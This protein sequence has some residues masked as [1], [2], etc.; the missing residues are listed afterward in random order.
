MRLLF[1]GDMVGKTGRTAVWEQ[2][3]GLIADFKLDFVI[4]NG[5]NAA[6]GFGITEEIFRETISAG[7]DVVT[8]GNHVWDQ[9]DALVFAP[10]EE[11]FLRPSNFPKGTPGRGSGVYIARNGARVL[12]ANIMGRV[13]MHPE[14]DDP[15]QAGERELT[16]CPLGE[17]ADAAVID[18]HAEATSE[19]MCF[20]HFVDGRASL[21]VG[22]HT[23]QPTGDH[24]ILNGGTG[25]ISDAGMCGDYD[26][27][28]GMDKEEPLN[29][30]LSK[31]PKGRFEA[32]TGPATLCGIGVEISDRTGLTERI[33]PFR[34]GPRLEETAPAFWL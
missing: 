32:A 22:T 26:S 18:F 33:A 7:A 16:A 5:E 11:R 10:R 27:S 28:L 23:H 2:L 29:R 4:V 1:L 9:R 30:F 34:R 20:A 19:K 21:V 6:G 12:V 25:Y 15:F 24:Q 8:T 13:F 14:L 17:Q 3:P 31:V